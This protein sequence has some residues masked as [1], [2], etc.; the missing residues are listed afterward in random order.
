MQ[1]KMKEANKQPRR[2]RK[3][4]QQLGAKNRNDQHKRMVTGRHEVN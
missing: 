2:K 4:N 1:F 3:T